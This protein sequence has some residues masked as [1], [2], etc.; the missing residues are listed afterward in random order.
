[1][2]KFLVIGL[3]VSVACNV[4]LFLWYRAAYKERCLFQQGW[5]KYDYAAD[6]VL[7]S[8]DTNWRAP[9]L[10]KGAYFYRRDGGRR[11]AE[12]SYHRRPLR[13]PA[14]PAVLPSVR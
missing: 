8:F 3:V 5:R 4:L 12:G 10:E 6:V 1:M 11:G 7:G 9:D 2:L 13:W 14:D